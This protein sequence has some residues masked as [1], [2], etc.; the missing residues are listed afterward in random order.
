MT[1]IDMTEPT[2]AGLDLSLTSTGVAKVLPGGKMW[3][4]R[5]QPG[6][7]SGHERLQYLAN[8]IMLYVAGADLVVVEGPSYGSAAGQRG[9]HERAGLWWHITYMLWI[10]GLGTAI[11][12]PA[13]LKRY[14]TGKGNA[15][16]D[17]VLAAA[18]RRYPAAELDGN[19]QADALILAAMGA[20]HL[21]HPPAEVPQ[22]Q[23]TAL[24]KVEWGDPDA[25][26]P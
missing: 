16:K 5:I 20:D 24:A 6:R 21:G 19:D 11:A 23:R 1:C 25:T 22:A 3:A 13:C 14:A 2:V 18:I 9:H 10:A 17:L 12:P 7:R 26:T 15:A 4:D 8:E